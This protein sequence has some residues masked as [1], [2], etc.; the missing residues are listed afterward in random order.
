MSAALTPSEEVGT[1]K[2]R[3]P[4][5][6]WAQTIATSAIEP[7]V[8]HILAPLRIQSPEG[9]CLAYVRIEPGSEPWSGSVRPKHPMT[10]PADMRGSHSYFCA[11][12][13][14]FQMGYI[15]SDPCTDTNDRRPESPASSSRQ[16]R[17]YET[18]S[19]PAQP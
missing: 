4:P 10:S 3:T 9:S 7:L 19:R 5:S 15:A 17:P 14:Y 11:A 12:V 16:A 1:T 2:P 6:V 8:I 13:P 18:A